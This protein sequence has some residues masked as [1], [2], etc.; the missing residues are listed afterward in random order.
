MLGL[1]LSLDSI[2]VLQQPLLGQRLGHNL[3]CKPPGS[4]RPDSHRKPLP[5]HRDWILHGFLN[6]GK[7]LKQVGKSLTSPGSFCYRCF[8]NQRKPWAWVN[9]GKESLLSTVKSSKCAVVP[10]LPSGGVPREQSDLALPLL[11]AR[12][13]INVTESQEKCKADHKATGRQACAVVGNVCW[14]LV[15]RL[16]ET[17]SQLCYL[18]PGEGFNPPRASVFSS[19]KWANSMHLTGWL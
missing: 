4:C 17:E 15:A 19:I 8:S 3:N 10:G 6:Q 7:A 5:Y 16:M 2:C 14:G 9:E 18:I 1:C 11:L 13:Q 12:K